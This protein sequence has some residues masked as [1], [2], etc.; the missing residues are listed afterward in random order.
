MHFKWN[1]LYIFLWNG[2]NNHDI[3][4]G[5][6]VHKGIISAVARVSKCWKIWMRMPQM[7]IKVMKRRTYSFYEELERV[8]DEFHDYHIIY[9]VRLAVSGA[10]CGTS[11]IHMKFAWWLFFTS[12]VQNFIEITSRIPKVK[13]ADG[14]T[15]SP[16]AGL[17][18]ILCT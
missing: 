10:L 7:T 5:F 9:Y 14:R 2:N 17:L 8:F 4:S 15:R 1:S 12:P 6:F 3:G 13:H 11:A 16:C 18:L